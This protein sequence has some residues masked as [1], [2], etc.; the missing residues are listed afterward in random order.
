MSKDG[1]ASDLIETLTKHPLNKQT[2]RKSAVLLKFRFYRMVTCCALCTPF[3]GPTV[4]AGY[5]MYGVIEVVIEHR[6]FVLIC[7]WLGL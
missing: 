3:D 6:H 5:V 7:L 4:S 2:T 1:R